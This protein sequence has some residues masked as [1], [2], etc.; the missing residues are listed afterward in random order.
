MQFDLPVGRYYLLV[1]SSY[2]SS[3]ASRYQLQAFVPGQPLHVPPPVG[4]TTYERN[5]SFAIAHG[6]LKS[7]AIYEA[8][9]WTEADYDYYYVDV[10]ANGIFE[11]ILL[12]TVA[13]ARTNSVSTRATPSE[14]DVRIP[15]VKVRRI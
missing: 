9:L 7:G 12:E 10:T 6:P 1:K 4:D 13:D 3:Q 14:F 8:L 5:D 11:T 2:G 15:T